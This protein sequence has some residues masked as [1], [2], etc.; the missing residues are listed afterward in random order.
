MIMRKV[1]LTLCLLA[2]CC[3]VS[4]AQTD[5]RLDWPTITKEMRPWAYWWW[6]GSA[7]DPQNIAKEMQRYHDGGLG[8]MHIIPIYGA[9][10]FESKYIQYLSPKW[11][12][13]M[14]CAVSEAR[15]RGMDV[16][17]TLGTGWCFGGPEVTA[18]EA[19][20]S[21]ACKPFEVAPGGAIRGK[22]DKASTQALVAY[23]PDGKCVELTDKIAEGG[24]V[25]WKAEGGPWTVYAV[26]QRPSRQKVKRP[27]PG[28]EGWM[29]NPFSGQAVTHYLERFTKAFDAYKGPRPR[30]IYHDSYE[31][32][33]N[34]APDL[35][36]E[37]EKRRGYR[38]QTQLPALFEKGDPETIARVKA[39]YRATI[40][41]MM[42]ENFNPPWIAWAHKYGM[43]A[44]DEAHG[45][46]G[47]LLDLYAA[48]DVPET[49]MF[50]TDRDVFVAK[51]SSSAAHVAGRKLTSCE[52]GTWLAEH[53]TETLAQVKDL[54]DELFLAGVNHVVYHGCCYSPDEAGW[55][56]WHFYASLEM[57][58]R[59]SI[60]RD[61]PALNTYIARCQSILQNGQPDSDVLLYWPI[62][63]QWHD[64]KGMNQNMVVHQGATWVKGRP[65]GDAAELLW[66]R[67]WGFDY[68]S[69]R[70]VL[71]AKVKDKQ[72]IEVPGGIYRA[73]VVPKTTHIPVETMRALLGLAK[74]GASVI[75]D[76]ELPTDVPGLANLEA[77]RAEL[78]SLVA[79][80]NFKA[81]A[82][83]A[84]RGC[85]LGN[86]QVLVGSID[87]A[88]EGIGLTRESVV[89]TPGVSFIRRAQGGNAHYFIANRGEQALDQW[90][91]LGTAATAVEI[92]D[93][94]TGATGLAA[95]KHDAKGAAQVYLQLVP[96]QS[97]I[98]R[99][100]AKQAPDGPKWVYLKPAG[101]PAP[102]A[103]TWKVEFIEGGP[104]LPKPFE[105]A[106]LASWT[107][108]ADPEAQRFAGAARYTLTFDAPAAGERWLLDL[109]Q[110]CQSARVKLNGKSLGTLILAPFRVAL[111]GVKPKANV[112]EVEV[113]NVSANRIRDLDRRK[114]AWKTFTDINIVNIDYRPFDASSWPLTDSGLL[115]PVTLTSAQPFDPAK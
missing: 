8:G 88:L 83:R 90:V 94:M 58:P 52:T 7:V 48:A 37:F 112:L 30:A 35:F 84:F 41:D 76:G 25:D 19:N 62:S 111:E 80:I 22:I 10:G 45:S 6:M 12:E 77:R 43:I 89:D 93:P 50:H 96:G 40:S 99:T 81:P 66:K 33:N 56:G 32:Q 69:D 23:S 29:L 61:V 27:S 65:F 4:G 46:P 5:K 100:F 110:V 47:N 106:K 105:T 72:G 20:A 92:M 78:K 73:I 42:V 68:A 63:D 9:K 79:D 55:P 36:K 101:A 60:W 107:A 114:V 103:G 98:L 24:T 2:L 95:V 57:N 85:P 54:L 34:W 21:V 44:R 51:A 26:S 109:G 15:Q 64:A 13:M 59:N 28:G 82:T 16:D 97:V 87:A 71:A 91:T 17:M 86:G 1:F 53:F 108:Q 3:A 70:Q 14:G 31:Y 115:G 74:A 113:T 11:M 18:D 39:D 67:G 104:A 38:L 49:E 102:L 75:F